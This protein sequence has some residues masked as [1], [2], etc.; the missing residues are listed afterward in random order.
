LTIETETAIRAI[1]YAIHHEPSA[2]AEQK[3][4]ATNLSALAV[5]AGGMLWYGMGSVWMG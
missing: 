2:V 3:T 4:E 5:S 1:P